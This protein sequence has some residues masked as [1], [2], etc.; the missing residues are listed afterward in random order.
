MIKLFNLFK[1]KPKT[2]LA[3]DEDKDEWFRFKVHKGNQI[4]LVWVF[5]IPFPLE[6]QK[7]G[8]TICKFKDIRGTNKPYPWVWMEDDGRECKD[9][10]L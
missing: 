1:T 10:E 7:D 2:V 4:W 6:L 8:T 9:A 3:R 5:G